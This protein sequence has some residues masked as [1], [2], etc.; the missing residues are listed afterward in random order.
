MTAEDRNLIRGF[1]KRI[2]SPSTDNESCS[3]LTMGEFISAIC[4]MKRQG[5]AGLALT[6]LHQI[7]W[8]LSVRLPF[9]NFSKSFCW[10]ILAYLYLLELFKLCKFVNEK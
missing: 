10:L 8:K 9:K 4:K 6:L 7:S 3:K 1:K 2:D 5:A